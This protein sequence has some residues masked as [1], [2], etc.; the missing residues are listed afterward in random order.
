M[1]WW[2]LQTTENVFL[3]HVGVGEPRNT[4]GVSRF[5][6]LH[7]RV[8]KFAKMEHVLRQFVSIINVEGGSSQAALEST[9]Q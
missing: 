7:L 6:R 9:S 3:A 1:R 4:V 5:H 8:E 2:L